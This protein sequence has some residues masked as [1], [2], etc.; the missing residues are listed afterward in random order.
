MSQV[1]L[2]P[3]EIRQAQA[4]R[5]RT[6]LVWLVGI[7]VLA[8]VG[9]VYFL[10]TMNL[11]RVNGDLRAQQ[12]INAQKQAEI[13]SLSE[14]A[15]LQT[16]I[17]SKRT[18]LE[19]VLANDVSW[20]G[21]LLD[22]SRIIPDPAYITTLNGQVSVQTGTVS[23]APAAGEAAGL[24]G[25]IKLDGKAFDVRT[26]ALWLTRLET[27][28]GWVNPWVSTASEGE[29]FNRQFEF[30]SGVDLTKAAAKA[31]GSDGQ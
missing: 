20:S 2:L 28:K 24:I 14:F 10:Q 29:P 22:L 15:D 4:A 26:V 7:V 23:V 18:L 8:A 25:S 31:V 9:F 11:S 3:P 5:R 6:A 27:V 21:V 19:T 16:E 12:E 1:N 17:Q 13:A 30:S